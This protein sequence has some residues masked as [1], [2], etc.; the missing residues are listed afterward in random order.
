MNSRRSPIDQRSKTSHFPFLKEAYILNNETQKFRGDGQ[1]PFTL[2]KSLL[3]LGHKMRTEKGKPISVCLIKRA[4]QITRICRAEARRGARAKT[5]TSNTRYGLSFSSRLA[6]PWQWTLYLW[7]LIYS[8]SEWMYRVT[9][10]SDNKAS[11]LGKIR[12]LD[13]Y[14]YI[15]QY[16]SK[17]VSLVIRYSLD[18][19]LISSRS[20]LRVIC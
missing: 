5:K 9:F 19:Q 15:E 11:H 14:T 7:N 13:T 18:D 20:T 4:E 8:G 6:R 12:W 16:H 2:R 10:Q 3:V 1:E 17:L